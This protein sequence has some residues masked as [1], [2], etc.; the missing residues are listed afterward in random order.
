MC[1][2]LA[3]Y[4][5]IRRMWCRSHYPPLG[6]DYQAGTCYCRCSTLQGR[7][8]TRC[9]P[10]SAHPKHRSRWRYR[11]R[12]MHENSQFRSFWS[13]LRTV[14]ICERLTVRHRSQ[15]RP[16]Y[17]GDRHRLA[18][19]RHINSPAVVPGSASGRGK[20]QTCRIRTCCRGAC[21]SGAIRVVCHSVAGGTG[22]GCDLCVRVIG[23]RVRNVRTNC[24]IRIV[25]GGAFCALPVPA[26][27]G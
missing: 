6:R 15:G 9:C 7:S 11:P 22:A 12:L 25:H 21:I 4:A 3:Q 13:L 24:D 8:C 17:S 5:C 19:S 18:S 10:C 20:G 2:C 14:G 27:V 1:E 26:R 23:A 16:T